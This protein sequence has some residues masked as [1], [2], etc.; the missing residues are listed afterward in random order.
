MFKKM[1]GYICSVICFFA[2]SI[3]YVFELVHYVGHVGNSVS[4]VTY[5]VIGLLTMA[6]L[7]CVGFCLR[8]Y[9]DAREQKIID[10]KSGQSLN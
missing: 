3:G 4:A 8:F 1:I 10:K 6:Y 9:G 2:V 5:V 7:I